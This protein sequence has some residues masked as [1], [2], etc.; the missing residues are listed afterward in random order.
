[1]RVSNLVR[2]NK[3]KNKFQLQL[4]HFGRL[5]HSQE[6]NSVYLWEWTRCYQVTPSLKFY[7]M[8][9]KNCHHHQSLLLFD[10]FASSAFSI[11]F[12]FFILVFNYIIIIFFSLL[13]SIYLFIYNRFIS[14]TH[15]LTYWRIKNSKVLKKVLAYKQV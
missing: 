15:W 11:F 8:I 12:R 9:I 3:I 7:K 14:L 5:V 6:N 2:L 10:Y 1:M 13:L 4:G